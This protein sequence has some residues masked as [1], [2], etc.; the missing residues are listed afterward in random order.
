MP[1]DILP[2]EVAKTVAI[3]MLTTMDLLYVGI[4]INTVINYKLLDKIQTKIEY[5]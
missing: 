2:L 1:K 5:K 4:D 3:N